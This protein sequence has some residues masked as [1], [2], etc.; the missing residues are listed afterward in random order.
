MAKRIPTHFEV[1]AKR[2]AIDKEKREQARAKALDVIYDKSLKMFFHSALALEAHDNLI[3]TLTYRRQFK[4]DGE[5]FVKELTRITESK[6]Q[7]LVEQDAEFTYN[8]TEK[9]EGVVNKLS[10]LRIEDYPMLDKVLDAYLA[11]KEF[12][13]DNLI[14]E[15]KR[16]RDKELIAKQEV[17]G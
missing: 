15:F 12:W 14:I 9:V 1:Q 8:M 16:N 2:D 17:N 6:Y 3:P 11:D 13:K 10:S 7:D 5:R 4:R